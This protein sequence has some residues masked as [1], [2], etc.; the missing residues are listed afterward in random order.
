M[1]NDNRLRKVAWGQKIAKWLIM[2]ENERQK[3]GTCVMM[4]A[5]TQVVQDEW[6]YM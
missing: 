1:H 2:I 5:D 4:L 3:M 6:K